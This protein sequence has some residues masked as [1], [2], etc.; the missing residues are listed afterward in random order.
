MASLKAQ[1]D[2]VPPQRICK[3]FDAVAAKFYK[4][5]TEEQYCLSLSETTE[6]PPQANSEPFTDGEGIR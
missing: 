6:R 5:L 2:L 4:D 3:W 1:S